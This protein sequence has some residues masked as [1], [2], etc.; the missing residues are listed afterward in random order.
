MYGKREYEFVDY[1]TLGDIKLFIVDIVFRNMHLHKEFEVFQVLRGQMEVSSPNKTLILDTGDFALFNPRQ[2]HQ[3]RSTSNMPVRIMPLQV[4]PN[5]WSRYYPQMSNVEFDAISINQHLRENFD[6][7][8][9]SY[10]Q[11]ADSYL[12][13]DAYYEMTCAAEVNRLMRLLLLSVPWHFLTEYEKK[14]KRYIS[15]RMSRILRYIEEHYTEK[16]LLRDICEMENLSFYRMSHYFTEQMNMSF[17]EYLSLL[18]FERAKVLVE[19]TDIKLADIAF[20]SGFSDVRYMNSVFLK[21]VGCSSSEYRNG[22]VN[23]T[24]SSLHQGQDA[25]EY[26]LDEEESLNFLCKLG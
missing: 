13:K 12:S 25:E 19:K 2:S 10:L 26:F 5:F 1:T 16:L 14:S 4:S 17:Q 21:L 20:S 18:R 7:F 24:L 3:F 11:V 6:S 15:Q 8:R 23:R 9:R 22:Q